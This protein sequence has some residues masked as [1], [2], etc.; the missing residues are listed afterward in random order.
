MRGIISDD[1]TALQKGEKS[2][3]DKRR[4]NPG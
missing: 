1:L 2:L 3:V 4:V